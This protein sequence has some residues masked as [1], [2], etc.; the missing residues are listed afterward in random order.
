MDRKSL[1]QELAKT[2][3]ERRVKQKKLQSPAYMDEF[4]N[5]KTTLILVVNK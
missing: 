3:L 2:T 4:S 1:E 5:V